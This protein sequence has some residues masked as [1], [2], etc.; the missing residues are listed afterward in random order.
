MGKRIR[1]MEVTDKEFN[2][3]CPRFRKSL[4]EFFTLRW[5]GVCPRVLSMVKDDLIKW[6]EAKH[7]R[8]GCFYEEKVQ[9]PRPENGM[10]GV[11]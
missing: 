2:Q 4:E 7:E 8:E 6:F 10:P 1:I 5:G 11:L 3:P 9:T